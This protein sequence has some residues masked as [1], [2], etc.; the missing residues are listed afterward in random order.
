MPR[1]ARLRAAL[2]QTG[3]DRRP[4]VIDPASNGLVGDR[5]PALREQIFDVSKAQRKPE[6]EPYCLGLAQT[7]W[8]VHEAYGSIRARKSSTPARPYI[9]RF[10]VLRRLICPS[11]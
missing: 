5:D 2:S 6:V 7:V 4:E 1:D 11:V 8:S 9:D 10:R 3:S